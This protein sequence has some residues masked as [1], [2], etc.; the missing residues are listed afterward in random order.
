M[1]QFLK[2]SPDEWSKPLERWAKINI[3]N[4]GADW[5]MLYEMIQRRHVIVHNGGRADADYLAKVARSLRQGL[6]P[7]SRLIC[8]SAYMQP[9]M[10]ELETWAICVALRFS[11]RFFKEERG[12]YEGII[13]RVTRLQSLGRWTQGVAIMDAFLLEPVPLDL[14][15]IVLAQIN[16]WFCLQELGKDNESIQ[17]EIRSW[18]AGQSMSKNAAEY[19]ELGRLALLRDYDGLV[20]ALN[21]YFVGPEAPKRKQRLGA[22]PLLQRAMQESP[23]VKSC[24]R[25]GGQS[26]PH[27]SKKTS[28]R[29]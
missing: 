7:G 29:R 16:R 9:V 4:V 27:G 1:T 14:E 10:I 8:N 6:Y 28:R 5:G 2:S 17:R 13:K 22:Q 11:K 15:D 21:N 3:T 19:R 12:I 25:G 26:H 23:R 20:V 18:R 24:I